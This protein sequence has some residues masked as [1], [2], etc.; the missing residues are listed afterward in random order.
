MSNFEGFLRPTPKVQASQG[1]GV[2]T[3]PPECIED[4]WK[5]LSDE[6]APKPVTTS[7]AQEIASQASISSGSARQLVANPILFEFPPEPPPLFFL[8]DN[9]GSA[10][11]TAM[12]S[13]KPV[14]E[15]TAQ[16][17]LIPTAVYSTDAGVEPT[18]QELLGVTS[19]DEH[20]HPDN[21][22]PL[23]EPGDGSG[24]LD[25]YAPSLTAE[26]LE[27]YNTISDGSSWKVLGSTS[28]PQA[29]P[30]IAQQPNSAHP[31]NFTGPSVVPSLVASELVSNV[32][33][34]NL[35]FP[36]EKG[37]WKS[38]PVAILPSRMNARSC[39]A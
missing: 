27:Y 28:L 6:S 22:S 35:K 39:P 30:T 18:I 4:P 33:L 25:A 1:Y 8:A 15:L 11:P 9:G 37:P 36:W 13:G 34:G 29:N 19:Q 16:G 10:M 32:S 26:E 23:S 20:Q 2:A 5:L 17:S 24:S 7:P 3:A 12:P 38:R 21:E 31:Q 14:A